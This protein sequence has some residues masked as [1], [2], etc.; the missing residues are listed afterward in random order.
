M[1]STHNNIVNRKAIQ[2]SGVRVGRPGHFGLAISPA[3]GGSTAERP[4]DDRKIQKAAQD[5]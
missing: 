2:T 1:S 4:G 3:H 5:E